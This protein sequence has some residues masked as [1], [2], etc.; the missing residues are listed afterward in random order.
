MITWSLAINNY[1]AV[2]Y[3]NITIQQGNNSSLGAMAH[4]GGV[5]IKA[6]DLV[7]MYATVTAAGS[8]Y[9]DPDGIILGA[10]QGWIYSNR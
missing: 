1:L 10:F 7:T 2:G 4:D 8:A 3:S 9:L 6:N 5:R